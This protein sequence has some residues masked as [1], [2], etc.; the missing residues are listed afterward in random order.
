MKYLTHL[1]AVLLVTTF[2]P[3]AALG[4]KPPPLKC[5]IGPVK[6]R[7]GK[8]PWLVYSC[9]DNI[10]VVIAAD[11]GSPA[12]PFYFIFYKKGDAYHLHGD[13]A[14]RKAATAAALR[15]IEKLSEPDIKR[16]I[17]ETM[18]VK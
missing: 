18:R 16:L 2:L 15:E 8:T 6:K 10:T 14:G 4:A 5:D 7:Y 9:S 13:G 12:M 11:T 3:F 1:L 17:V